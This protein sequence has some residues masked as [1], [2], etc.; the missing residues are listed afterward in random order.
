MPIYAAPDGLEANDGSESAPW[1]L[2]HAIDHLD[3]T[4]DHVLVLLAGVYDADDVAISISNLKHPDPPYVISGAPSASVVID[5]SVPEFRTV[6]NDLWEHVGG[7]DSG[8]YRSTMPSAETEPARGS[9]LSRRPYTRLITHQ[10]LEDLQSENELAGPICPD[11][12]LD[13]PPPRQPELGHPEV[14]RRRPW[15]Y[16]GPGL[17][18]NPAAD[19][20]RI[21]VRLSPTHHYLAGFPDYDGETDPRKVPLAIWFEQRATVRIANCNSVTFSN[22]TVRHGDTSVTIEDCEDVLLDHVDVDAG[23]DGIKLRGTC[24][25]VT[26]TNVLVD[27]GLPPWYFRSDRKGEFHLASDA[28]FQRAQAPGQNTMKSLLSGTPKCHDSVVRNCEFVNGHD[29]YTFGTG[30][31][32]SRNWI[33]NLDDDATVIDTEGSADLRIFENVVEQCQTVLSSGGE[34][35]GAGT[36]VFRNL[37]DLRRPFAKSRPRV[38]E[39][40]P[41]D[42]TDATE[43]RR[44]LDVGVLVK[45]DPPD[46]PLHFF[47]NTCVVRDNQVHASFNHLSR[48]GPSRRQVFNNIFVAVNS[49][50]DSDKPISFLPNVDV[51]LPASSDDAAT[52]GNCFFR[53][54][55]YHFEA[56]LAVR[57]NA[58]GGQ[59]SFDTLEDYRGPPTPSGHFI[60][61]QT[62]YV[63]GFENSSIEADPQF[64][65]FGPAHLV[66]AWQ[67]DFR[68]WGEKPAGAAGVELQG[69]LA[70]MDTAPHLTHPAM[71]FLPLGAAPLTVGVDGRRV[72]PAPLPGLLGTSHGEPPDTLAHG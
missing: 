17:F 47:H 53:T 22:V 40:T 50:A 6:P 25:R 42:E 10:F 9:F 36:S 65:R 13:G 54:G 46:G 41:C 35:P 48:W 68:L 30:L 70:T 19:D 2:Q 51:D 15:M 44:T 29:L 12:P 23:N 49:V 5:G 21:H 7:P 14:A 8:E 64:R 55:Q 37:I 39:K 26:L 3:E 45:P 61:S 58:S 27:G 16:L 67:D 57:N 43:D 24:N 56:L 33:Q 11:N 71:G 4:V 69:P 32:F 31:R 52:D 60:G 66:P 20:N 62:I 38:Y 34:V 1:P 28:T 18:H 63:P 72:F 59:A